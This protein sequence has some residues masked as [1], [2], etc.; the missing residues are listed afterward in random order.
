ML[1]KVLIKRRI[2][3]GKLND[4]F[5]HLRIIRSAAMKQE[6]YVSGETLIEIELRCKKDS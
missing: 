3:E 1:T 2:K 6:G 4:V 5:A